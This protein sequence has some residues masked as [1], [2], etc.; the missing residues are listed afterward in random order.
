LADPSSN[1]TVIARRYRPVGFEDLIGQEHV[2]NA[3][4]NAVSSGRIAHAYLFTGVRGVGK[5][6]VAR[7]MA[8]AL[9]CVKGPTAEPCGTCEICKAITAGEDVDVLEIDGASNRGIDRIREIRANVQYLP[10]RA[11]F[12]IYIIDEVHM[13][14]E[15]AFNALLKTLEEPP[16]H[17][18]FFFATTDPQEIPITILSRCQR[19]N[20]DGIAQDKILE[21]LKR[22]VTKEKMKADEDAL[23]LIARRASGSMRDAQSLLDQL[24]AFSGG[25]LTTDS[26]RQLL[27]SA[28]DERMGQIAAAI[29]ADDVSGLLRLVE[30]CASEGLPLVELLDQLIAYWRDL[31]AIQVAGDQAPG[32]TIG[33]GLKAKVIEQAKGLS[34]DQIT[35]G[36]DLLAAT[37]QKLKFSPLPRALVEVAL[38]RLARLK[39]LIPLSQLAQAVSQGT[40][41]AST[42][43]PAQTAPPQQRPAAT[44]MSYT[45]SGPVKKNDLKPPDSPPAVSSARST[46][47]APAPMHRQMGLALEADSLISV[48]AETLSAV[49]GLH[50]RELRRGTPRLLGERAIVLSF[51]AGLENSWSYCNEGPRIK[52][53][54]EALKSVTG[55]ECSIRFERDGSVPEGAVPDAPV[56]ATIDKQQVSAAREAM[57]R[58]E[59]N[60]VVKRAVE[61]FDGKIVRVDEGFGEE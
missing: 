45:A 29:I 53:V 20:L 8:R 23:R 3:L 48:W 26:V 38:V 44:A 34:L 25:E 35:A 49:G 15:E 36:M 16:P 11:R 18:K 17:V 31:M 27:G 14:T 58:A 55:D 5:T 59:L 50:E 37:R 57:A 54:E 56:V 22:I 32:L 51:G 40:M 21:H 52:R 6:S 60:P 39:D 41:R 47:P 30:L 13:L 4:K 9:N 33:P 12:K 2:A 42:A 61:L 43:S 10:S 46:P 24:L 28:D 7:I 19:F 1:Y